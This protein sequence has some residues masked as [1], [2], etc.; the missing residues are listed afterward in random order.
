MTRGTSLKGMVA[1]RPA[2]AVPKKHTGILPSIGKAAEKQQPLSPMPAKPS[3]P[4]LRQMRRALG[5]RLKMKQEVEAKKKEFKTSVEPV[6]KKTNS[7][8]QLDLSRSVLPQT[9]FVGM[10]I[11]S[12][13]T[14]IDDCD[15]DDDNNET[16]L[17]VD[18]ADNN[19]REVTAQKTSDDRIKRMIEEESKKPAYRGP[20]EPPEG[21]RL[22]MNV[23]NNF[24]FPGDPVNFYYE[25]SIDRDPEHDAMMWDFFVLHRY[26]S[27]VEDY[28]AS[29]YRM[30]QMCGNSKFYAPTVPGR[31]SISAV[32][33]LKAVL[34]KMPDG[35]RRDAFKVT[36][37]RSKKEDLRCIGTIDCVVG[38]PEDNPSDPC[39]VMAPDACW[40]HATEYRRDFCYVTMENV[41]TLF[42]ELRGRGAV[43]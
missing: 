9:E 16:T 33:D 26:G 15:D 22:S 20:I 5:E 11:K 25:G 27:P 23:E 40:D 7:Q 6:R 30:S 4:R 36:V 3:P 37:N 35:E 17:L 19:R 14:L 34:R 24:S 38:H 2:R 41:P 8:L 1:D 29:R 28:E 18:V 12:I 42:P 31:Y 21:W 32:R 43:R 39:G 10:G 13:S